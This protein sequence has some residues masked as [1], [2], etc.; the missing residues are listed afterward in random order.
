M[1]GL[2]NPRCVDGEREVFCFDR[3]CQHLEIVVRKHQT[4]KEVA[5]V[6][7]KEIFVKNHK[8]G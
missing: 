8:Y 4:L 3:S 2:L 6:H 5:L 7:V 1:V